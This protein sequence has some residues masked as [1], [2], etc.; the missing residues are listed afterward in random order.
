MKVRH[1]IGAALI[2]VIW[3]VATVFV[4]VYLAGAEDTWDP[5]V[6]PPASLER[7]YTILVFPIGD[8]PVI[9]LKFTMAGFLAN[10]VL[11][12]STLTFAFCL[13]SRFLFPKNK[14]APTQE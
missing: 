8:L 12:G 3:F 6:R 7:L 10:S 1:I 2:S 4:A 9:D 5:N 11:W 13:L 14:N